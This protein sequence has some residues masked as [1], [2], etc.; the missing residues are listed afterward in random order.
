MSESRLGAV[1]SEEKLEEL[2]NN[3]NELELPL[4]PYDITLGELE[5]LLAYHGNMLAYLYANLDL[6]KCEEEEKRKKG[7]Q[8]YNEV[9]AEINKHSADH[10]VA[11]IKAIASTN[12]RVVAAQEEL[13]AVKR[14][15]ASVESKIN[16]LQEQNVSLRK[17]ASIKGIALQKGLE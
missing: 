9:Y 8:V 4:I 7:E 13:K 17:I 16:A 1:F 3:L 10:K 11:T 5:Q 14:I 15:R 12:K 2:D 6:V